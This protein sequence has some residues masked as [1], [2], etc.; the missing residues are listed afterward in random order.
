MRA[1]WYIVWYSIRTPGLCEP[2]G[3]NALQCEHFQ[4]VSISAQA[5]AVAPRRYAHAAVAGDD[6]YRQRR[7][8][9]QCHAGLRNV[10]CGEGDDS[11]RARRV[12][13]KIKYVR[14][15]DVNIYGM[16]VY[17]FHVW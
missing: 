7:N 3:A 5:E 6:R 4:R 13:P 9:H 8:C 2:F 15:G 14:L 16:C 1:C 11:E 17:G 12:W 10:D